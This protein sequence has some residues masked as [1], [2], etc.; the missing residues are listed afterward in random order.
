MPVSRD[1]ERHSPYLVG[2]DHEQRVLKSLSVR[3]SSG[4]GSLVLIGGEA[5]I[6]KTTLV[7]R[8]I[9]ETVSDELTRLTGCCYDVASTPPYALWRTVIEKLPETADWFDPALN[10]AIAD[11]AAFFRLIRSRLA[12]IAE[13][14][15]TILVLEDAHW[16]D[17]ESLD[18][19]RFIG[20]RVRDMP[21][22]IFVTYRNDEIR[23]GQPFYDAL[24]PLVR[25]CGAERIDLRHLK[26]PDIGKI[27]EA[28][29]ALDD[30]DQARLVG[31]LSRRTGGNP[32]FIIELLRSMELADL[33]R[34]NGESWHLADQVGTDIPLLVRQLI[35]RRLQLLDPDAREILNLASVLG[36]E[37]EPNLLVSASGKPEDV[38]SAGLQQAIDAT[39]LEQPLGRQQIRF[40]HALIHEALYAHTPILWRQ[41]Q[42]RKI[43]EILAELPE[44]DPSRIAEHFGLAGDP[45][46]AFW[47]LES[48]R[49]ARRLFAPHAVIQHL[50]PVLRLPEMLP[51]ENRIEASGLRGWAYEMTGSFQQA[52]DD[53]HAELTWALE[54]DDHHAR[55]DALVRLAELWTYRDYQRVVEYVEQALQVTEDIN[56][57]SLLAQT[58][59]RFGTWYISQDDPERARAHHQRALEIC[60]QTDDQAGLAQSH[61]LLGLALSLSGDLTRAVHQHQNAQEHLHT[62]GDRQSLS[63]CL[64]NIAHA[65]PT[66]LAD[67]AVPALSLD[68]CIDAGEQALHVAEEIDYRAGLVY[69]RVRLIACF[70]ASGDYQRALNTV[71][72]SIAEASMTGNQQLLSATHAMAGLL[73]LDLLDPE[74]AQAHADEVRESAEQLGST[75]RVR[76]GNAIL[77]LSAIARGDFSS[78]ESVLQQDNFDDSTPA[79]LAQYLLCRA[80]IELDLARGD[81]RSALDRTDLLIGSIPG[82][83]RDRPALRA[84]YL[85]GRALN[86][87]NHFESA[88]SWLLPARDAAHAFG[89]HGLLWRIQEQLG[90]AFIGLTDR[91]SAQIAIDNARELV[92]NLS[93]S[94]ESPA[95]RSHFC[96]TAI[97][98]IPA[99]P[100]PTPLQAAKQSA[101]GLTRRQRQVATLIAAGQSNRLIADTLSISE[102]TVESHVSAIL[103]TL[104]LDSRAQIVAWSIEHGLNHDS[105]MPA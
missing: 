47:S 22:L 98:R 19:L 53:Y 86:D 46:A 9:D 65:G 34:P 82:A 59:N 48:A 72:Q 87:L 75:F 73:W 25:E 67:V 101:G 54:A 97:A 15:T 24:L 99:A 2:R 14:S 8:F 40:R 96:R 10:T 50:E 55:R 44:T 26:D 32:L 6:G 71:D 5:G 21:L 37:L 31:I 29:Y 3:A 62:I 43:G 56:D 42:H 74:R 90:R 18:L 103:A 91:A 12:E 41:S 27:V 68:E 7:E 58:H 45:R 4:Q 79:T 49:H 51:I 30:A 66:L 81:A 63:N 28:R 92:E 89:S 38:V 20:Q 85:R 57:L 93:A 1:R 70:G 83:S 100:G 52:N 104:N 76:M 17:Q 61:D 64:A 80:L 88:I 77:A 11:Q 102:R 84:S 33:L 78:A 95:M 13:D 39:L 69:A 36:F 60:Q 35:E 94:I 105:G 16:A 23:P